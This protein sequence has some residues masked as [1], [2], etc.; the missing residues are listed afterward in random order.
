LD[1]QFAEA[2]ALLN[3][4]QKRIGTRA[5]WYEGAIK[6][7]EAQPTTINGV[8]GGFGEVHEVDTDTSLKMI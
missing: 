1:P 7:W 8:L 4:N 6:Y 2:A 3:D 5:D